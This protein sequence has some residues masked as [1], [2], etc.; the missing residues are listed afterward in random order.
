L[1]VSLVTLSPWKYLLIVSLPAMV[2]DTAAL[3]LVD[4]ISRSYAACAAYEELDDEPL[5]YADLLEWQN[6]LLAGEDTK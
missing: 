5:Q 2:A 3:N 6:E 4:E 1:Y